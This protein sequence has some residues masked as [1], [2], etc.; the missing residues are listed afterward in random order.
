M[1]WNEYTIKT[2]TM[3]EELMCAMLMEN[4]VE[5]VEILDNIPLTKQEKELMYIDIEP[6]LPADEGDAYLRFFLEAEREDLDQMLDSIH[7]GMEEVANY[8]NIGEGTMT[9]ELTNDDDWLHKWKEFFKPFLV[10]D[11]L[12]KP[13]WE[14]IDPSMKD[15]MMIEIDPGTSFGTGQHE[16]T[17]LCIRSL[18]K[19]IK[20]GDQMLDLGTGSG[21]LSIV[22]LKSGAEHVMGTDIDP[23]C[24]EACRENMKR[25]HIEPTTYHFY[26]GD[27]IQDSKIQEMV[28][29]IQ[30]DIAVA[31]ILADVIIPMAPF[32]FDLLKKEGLFITS[33]IIDFKENPVK[34]ALTD[35]GFTILNVE[36]QGEWVGITARK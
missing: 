19:Y 1:N 8:I 25:N 34:K 23:V 22:G 28:G 12:I 31:N 10:D 24:M 32:V 20:N 7:K 36:H 13:S 5:G 27:L 16:T 6:T 26:C 2:T 11:I 17:Q 3:A 9:C 33:G 29:T 30:Y 14:E 4:G 18:K 35:A 15:K 21:I